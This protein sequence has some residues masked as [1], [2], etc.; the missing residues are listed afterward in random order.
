MYGYLFD[1]R[2]YISVLANI[3][4]DLDPQYDTDWHLDAEEFL[5]R[6]DDE[7][8]DTVLYDPPFS[9]R[10]VSE[11]YKK[12]GMTVNRETTQNSYWRRQK[13]QISRISEL[14]HKED[15]DSVLADLRL[16][17]EWIRE[18]ILQTYDE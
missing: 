15:K 4:N 11:C 7:S 9:S 6:F 16:M 8:V 14:L 12:F 5:K 18:I 13:E 2:H 1:K 3:T 10:Q 17:P